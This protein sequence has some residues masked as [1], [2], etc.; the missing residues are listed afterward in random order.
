MVKRFLVLIW[1]VFFTALLICNASASDFYV[2]P[3][4]GNNKNSGRSAQTAWRSPKKITSQ[5]QIIFITSSDEWITSTKNEKLQPQANDQAEANISASFEQMDQIILGARVLDNWSPYENAI[6]TFQ[7]P[8]RFDSNNK[9][10]DTVIIGDRTLDEAC[11]NDFLKNNSYFWNSNLLY[12]HSSEGNPGVI[13]APV[14][15]TF[16]TPATSEYTET[17][18]DNWSQAPLTVWQTDLANQPV[19]L[20]QNGE[21]Y[22]DYW[23]GEDDCGSVADTLYVRSDSGAPNTTDNIMSLVTTEEVWQLTAGDFNADGLMDVVTSDYGPNLFIYNG[24]SNFS[25]QASK[26]IQAPNG[27][28]VLGFEV[29]AAGDVNQDG[30]EDLLVGLD[31]GVNRAYLYFGAEQGLTADNYQT[32]EVPDEQ[33][34]YGF[35]HDLASAGDINADGYTDILISGGGS[36]VCVYLGND[37]G[38]DSQ[39]TRILSFSGSTEGEIIKVAG[40]G[41][42]NG[43]GFDD[44]VVSPFQTNVN[45]LA[46]DV[47]YGSEEGVQDNPQEFSFQISQDEVSKGLSIDTIG[48]I[49]GDQ[50]DDVLIADPYASVEYERQGMAYL[51]FGGSEGIGNT[52]DISIE[53]PEPEEN[54]RFGES[55]SDIGDFDGDGFD[56]FAISSPS[57]GRVHFFFGSLNFQSDQYIVLENPNDIGWSISPVGNLK[58]NNQHFIG[59]A[60]EFGA[61]YLYSL[62]EG[63]ILPMNDAGNQA[64]TA[65]AGN[66]QTVDEGTTVYLD[67]SGSSDPDDGIA[68]WHWTQAE[69]PQVVLS[70]NFEESPCFVTPAVGTAEG[71]TLKFNLT[72]SDHYNLQSNAELTIL[73]TDNGIT[74]FPEDAITLTTSDGQ[75]MGF[76]IEQ[77]G[78]LVS[79]SAVSPVE[80]I[81]VD[82]WENTFLYD[83]ISVNIKTIEV[84]GQV[85]LA[86]YL[87]KAVEQEIKVIQYST[88]SGWHDI[89]AQTNFNSER[90]QFSLIQTDGE[91]GDADLKVN[92]LISID[93]FGMSS[94][95]ELPPN[96]SKLSPSASSSDGANGGCFINSL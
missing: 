76:K 83:L 44:F 9:A 93:R 49:N 13:D 20:Y 3:I 10:I 80:F 6:N 23:W 45:S 41:D 34:G 17:E 92:G 61:A 1:A 88:N 18:V 5:D 69:G 35:G 33:A 89:S 2:D 15:V 78:S 81:D 42:I 26:T 90:K 77:G 70:N 68:T 56:D 75:Q 91:I 39:P 38:V 7:A 67:G 46:V 71:T 58:G 47:F 16:F 12:V 65:D 73:V 62:K 8:L 94:G 82:S 87:S 4:R 24:A 55:L 27:E 79:L 48:D 85:D 36:Y 14:T 28:D 86:C 72:V 95:D 60:E 30:Y 19:Q 96:P 66:D 64:P 32:I 40:L 37:S 63:Q 21:I 59:V 53:N 51:Y 11:S 31:W 50:F 74:G 43:D 29:V 84:P 22:S 57:G 54:V 52:P 25:S